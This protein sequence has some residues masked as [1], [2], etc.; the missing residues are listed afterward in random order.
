MTDSGDIVE[1]HT[2]R[3]QLCWE[4]DSLRD[5]IT[6]HFASPPR[7]GHEGV[8]LPRTF[9]SMT[10]MQIAGVRIVATNNLLGHLRLTHDDTT[11]HV[12][13]HASFLKR[14]PARFKPL[15]GIC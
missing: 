8:K 11:L 6:A 13:Y 5:C 10:L 14:Q 4:T 9:N 12:V 7:L 15:D 3:E 2:G 1:G